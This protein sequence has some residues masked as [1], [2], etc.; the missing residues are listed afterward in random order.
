MHSERRNEPR[1]PLPKI[2]QAVDEVSGS[3]IGTVANISS[4]GLLILC[5]Q[6]IEPNR[7][8]QLNIQVPLALIPD[9]PV[10]TLG[11]E[12]VWTEADGAEGKYW[13]GFRIIDYAPDAAEILQRLIAQFS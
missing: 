13:C 5:Y 3:V 1:I 12:S 9:A 11:V 8:L 2:L 4:Q 7:I 10:L 6:C